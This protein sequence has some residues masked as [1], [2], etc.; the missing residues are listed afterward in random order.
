MHSQRGSNRA[1]RRPLRLVGGLAF[2]ALLACPGSPTESPPDEFLGRWYYVGSNGGIAGTGVGDAPL[3]Y[4]EIQPDYTIASYTED[5][6]HQGSTDFT[7]SRGPT[8]FSGDD[9]WILKSETGPPQVFMMA[10]SGEAMSLAENVYDG[11]S[12]SYVRSR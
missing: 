12:R 9:M 1:R 2:L 3:G 5:G 7:L 6:T 11:F 4:I 8:I 10:E